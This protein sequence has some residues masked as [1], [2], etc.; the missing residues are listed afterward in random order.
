MGLLKRVAELRKQKEKARLLAEKLR[1]K[2]AEQARKKQA[3]EKNAKQKKSALS[4]LLAR[5]WGKKMA[6]RAAQ[7]ALAAPQK[8]QKAPAEKG[9]PAPIDAARQRFFMKLMLNSVFTII[10]LSIILAV[11]LRK[12]HIALGVWYWVLAGLITAT[13]ILVI[14][15][16]KSGKQVVQR[17][18]RIF[19]PPAAAKK[20]YQTDLDKLY[21]MVQQK[22]SV[23]LGE[24]MKMF[25]IDR[26]KGE[27]WA[28]ILED[29]GLISIHYP[30]FG[31]P[32]LRVKEHG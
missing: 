21:E 32:E 28:A 23:R 6:K 3:A 2:A 12:R 14:F 10:V 7:P 29:S 8:P 25:S 31:D 30:A 22:Q 15:Y 4:A 27:E 16:L 26:K 9:A 11:V 19:A 13:I 24:V 5:L 18:K 20:E 1:K 17:V